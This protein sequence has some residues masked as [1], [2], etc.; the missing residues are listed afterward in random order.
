MPSAAA[1]ATSCGRSRCPR[2]SASAPLA[3]SSPRGRVFA[4]GRSPVGKCTRPPSSSRTSSCMKIVSAPGGNGAPVKMRRVNAG[5]SAHVA[6]AP[7]ARRPSTGK[8]RVFCRSASRTAYPSTAALSK[9][10][11]IDRRRQVLGQYTT[12][13]G[14]QTHLFNALNA[15]EA[16][17]D[18][19][20]RRIDCQKLAAE[21]EAVIGELGHSRPLI[22]DSVTPD[23]CVHRNRVHLDDIGNPLDVVPDDA[24]GLSAL[25]GQHPTRSR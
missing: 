14:V 21:G 1:S 25:A 10:R 13:R 17:R 2:R 23:D 24:A 11:Q 5:V 4:P 19:L 16:G 22:T 15:R 6:G 3:I 7:A 8:S 12:V 20:Q 18:Q 9:R